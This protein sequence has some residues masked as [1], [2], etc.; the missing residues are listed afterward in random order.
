MKLASVYN[1][2]VSTSLDGAVE[3]VCH[4]LV[5]NQQV[6]QS[7]ASSCGDNPKERGTLCIGALVIK[8]C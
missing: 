8:C 2:N 6:Q 1:A 3:E 5:G 4:D 7:R